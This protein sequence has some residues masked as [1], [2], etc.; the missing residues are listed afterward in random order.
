MHSLVRTL[1]VCVAV[2]V[3]GAA[4][5]E[6][7]EVVKYRQSVMKANG[8]HMAAAGAIVQGK[9]AHKDRLVDHARALESLNKNIA[10]LF[11][12]GSDKE[13]DAREEV[14]TKWAEFEK[15][16]KDAQDK[17]AAFAKA[18]A[19]NDMQGAAARYKELGGTCKACHQDFRSD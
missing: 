5:A 10:T 1:I 12:K 19:A 11:P 3:S 13:S 17:S 15:R 8:G 4:F 9:V 7:S 18:V 2:I 16:A 14:W 6:P